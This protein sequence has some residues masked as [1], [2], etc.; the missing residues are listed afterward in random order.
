MLLLASLVYLVLYHAIRDRLSYSHTSE[1]EK[2]LQ[3]IR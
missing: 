1:Q 2:E 3:Q